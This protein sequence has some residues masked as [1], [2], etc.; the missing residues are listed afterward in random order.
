MPDSTLDNE[1]DHL[2][3]H[4]EVMTTP[5][6][7]EWI[8]PAAELSHLTTTPIVSTSAPPVV[9]DH[10]AAQTPTAPTSETTDERFERLAKMQRELG[11]ETFRY[12]H[13]GDSEWLSKERSTRMRR[14]AQREKM[15]SL[16]RS[17][18]EASDQAYRFTQTMERVRL[19]PRTWSAA[20]NYSGLAYG[21]YTTANTNRVVL[22]SSSVL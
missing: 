9:A 11:N 12:F 1:L 15:E 16:G 17:I 7:L 14:M 2:M 5:D 19:N 22:S 4:H 6:H 21:T 13:K 8:V 10:E 18:S 3:I 20:T